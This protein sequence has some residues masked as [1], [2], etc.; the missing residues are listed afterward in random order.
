MWW[1]LWA[2]CKPS[3]FC[4]LCIVGL[5]LYLLIWLNTMGLDFSNIH[6][7]L[8]ACRLNP[9]L[10][11]PPTLH[12]ASPT[13][14]IVN[15]I[16]FKR[17]TPTSQL[18]V[19]IPFL[20]QKVR[21]DTNDPRTLDLNQFYHVLIYIKEKNKR[22]FEIT[23]ES[24]S[25]LSSKLLQ[26]VG[27]LQKSH[28]TQKQ[29]CSVSQEVICFMGPME[30]LFPYKSSLTSLWFSFQSSE[31][32]TCINETV[33]LKLHTYSYWHS[34]RTSLLASTGRMYWSPCMY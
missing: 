26:N 2:K 25:T 24:L 29:M 20:I 21:L 32:C 19:A 18:P 31:R 13:A 16:L 17:C 3:Q 23:T 1:I 7:N 6:T 33:L 9:S 28:T 14:A 22:C 34:K 30:S 4:V 5:Y 10:T 11:S 8:Q 15:S 27:A 12:L